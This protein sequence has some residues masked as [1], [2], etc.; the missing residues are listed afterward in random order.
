[1]LNIPQ[2]ENADED[3]FGELDI[4]EGYKFAE[5]DSPKNIVLAKDGSI[6]AASLIKLVERVTYEKYIGTPTVI[7]S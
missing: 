1:L 5:K 2:Q 4:P 7:T 6:K 3:E